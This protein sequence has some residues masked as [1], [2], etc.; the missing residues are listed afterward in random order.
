MSVS[1]KDFVLIS[2]AF[3]A[4]QL[5]EGKIWDAIKSKLGGKAS[6]DEIE[7]EIERLKKTKG[8]DVDAIKKTAASKDFHA[9]QAQKAKDDAEAA[10][11]DKRRAQATIPTRAAK[12]GAEDAKNR[13][14]ATSGNKMR[15][16]QGRAAERAWVMGEG[17]DEDHAEW[18]EGFKHGKAVRG[19]KAKEDLNGCSMAYKQGF[20]KAMNEELEQLDEAQKEYR[21][22]YTNKAGGSKRIAKIKAMDVTAVREKFR[23]DFHGMKILTVTPAKPAMAKKPEKVDEDFGPLGPRS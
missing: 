6:D 2:D 22:E 17:K 23:R 13:L 4:A 1:F 16:A 11:V 21:V 10:L 15:A 3:I 19:G 12:D 8:K 5:D 18:Q 9:R 7:A 20:K 14:A